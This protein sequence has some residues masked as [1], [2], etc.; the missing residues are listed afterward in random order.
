MTLWVRLLAA[1]GRVETRQWVAVGVSAVLHVAVFLGLR[2][3]PPPEPEQVTFEIA[4][5]PPEAVRVPKP[6]VK[7]RAD[8]TPP[9]KLAKAK[10]RKTQKPRKEPHT[11]QAQFKAE[12]KAVTKTR[13]DA[14]VVALPEAV[15]VPQSV[16]AE[17]A[18]QM[19]AA[20]PAAA[21][22]TAPAASVAASAA[23]EIS[24]PGAT[25]AAASMSV[26]ASGD[27]G[28][29]LSATQ[30]LSPSIGANGAQDAAGSQS[31]GA[32]AGPGA[33]TFSAAGVS[34]NG[35]NTR[36]GVGAQAV[37]ASAASPL[38]G[39]EPQGVRLT[40][41]GVLS[42]LPELP[43]G[44]GALAAGHLALEAGAASPADGQGRGQALTSTAAGGASASPLA[45]PAA[46]P[47]RGGQGTAIDRV[48][49][50]GQPQDK[51]PAAPRLASAK[52]PGSSLV[53]EG[54]APRRVAGEP[55]GQAQAPAM[56]ALAL[57][58]GEPGSGPQWA[59]IMAPIQAGSP[60][61]VRQAPRGAA[62]VQTIGAPQTAAARGGRGQAGQSGE[63]LGADEHS[64]KD[65]GR[66]RQTGPAAAS[67]SPL[68][69]VSGQPG[70]A[71]GA[72]ARAPEMGKTLLAS[73]GQTAQGQALSVRAPAEQKLIRQDS[74]A[75]AL[76]VLAPSN[77]CPLPVHPQPDNRAPQAS[78]GIEQPGYAANNPILSYPL[79]ANI[80]GVRGKLIL[81]VEVQPDG[82]PGKMLVKQASGSRLLDDHAI[83]ELA[84]W[85]FT[86]A[87]K[88]GQAVTAW[89]DVPI[90]FRLP[91]D[92]K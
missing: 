81:R 6:K 34:G 73:A 11:L 78:G 57:A 52:V 9:K 74:R 2:Q 13:R 41:S 90:D 3:A 59:I 16:R 5:Q 35:L 18:P 44:Q 12:P 17:A 80:Q 22:E 51:P 86:P 56:R 25:S 62:P 55:T 29:T 53:R 14:P 77:Y 36:N 63:D 21:P 85:R 71:S 75:E 50:P 37:T 87:R 49:V 46:G 66:L 23:P 91:A 47:G 72:A 7:A 10:P 28:L 60:M 43:Q 61:G 76:D 79:L 89:V 20:R 92:R 31:Q 69:G 67:L 4:L 33:A 39:G 64:G 45:G 48:A 70:S 68:G 15:A 1:L 40:A 54:V 38:P 58:P 24:M 65:A 27:A 19:A 32:N 84:R 83:A 88:L 8:K 42:R 30:S 82:R 26:A